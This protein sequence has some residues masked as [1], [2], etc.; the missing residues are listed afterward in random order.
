M[1]LSVQMQTAF[2]TCILDFFMCKLVGE[3]AGFDVPLLRGDTYYTLT[4][5]RSSYVHNN[6]YRFSSLLGTNRHVHK[7]LIKKR[8]PC[9]YIADYQGTTVI[10]HSIAGDVFKFEHKFEHINSN[11]RF[12]PNRKLDVQSHLKGYIDQPFNKIDTRV[13]DVRL[14]KCGHF[15]LTHTD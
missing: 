1:K 3:F 15:I 14:K 9:S 10:C 4:S 8:T 12:F 6:S 2:D 5:G 11:R 7:W 13:V